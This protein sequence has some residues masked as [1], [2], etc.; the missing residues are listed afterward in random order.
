MISRSSDFM[1]PCSRSLRSMI[2]MEKASSFFLMPRMRRPSRVTSVTASYPG[3]TDALAVRISFVSA[4]R[5]GRGCRR[6][7]RAEVRQRLPDFVVGRV[8]RRHFRS[9]HAA[10]HVLKE[11]LIGDAR[12]HDGREIRPAKARRI[13]AVTAGAADAVQRG[14]VANRLR[15]AFARVLRLTVLRKSSARGTETRAPRTR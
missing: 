11:L 14:P 5:G 4:A 12:R 15:I 1:C 2:C 9:R 10:L 7:E 6:A 8:G 13:H 3:W